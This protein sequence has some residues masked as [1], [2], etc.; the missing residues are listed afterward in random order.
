MLDASGTCLS[1][2]VL[3]IYGPLKRVRLSRYADLRIRGV[4]DDGRL[5]LPRSHVRYEL[6]MVGRVSSGLP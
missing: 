4:L 1:H 5:D 2:T 3:M 6:R